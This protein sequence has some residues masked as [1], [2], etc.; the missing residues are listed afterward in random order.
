MPDGHEWKTRR[1]AVKETEKSPKIAGKPKRAELANIQ[2]NI[3]NLFIKT[4][5]C[6]RNTENTY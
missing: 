4:V 2:A 3:F 5:V 1:V 6:K